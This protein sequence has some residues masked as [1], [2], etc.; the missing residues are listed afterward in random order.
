MMKHEDD[1]LF[2]TEHPD[3]ENIFIGLMKKR[4]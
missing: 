1:N 4:N 3:I 2:S